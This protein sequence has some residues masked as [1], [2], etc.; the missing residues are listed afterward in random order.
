MHIDTS[1]LILRNFCQEDADD[2]FDYLSKPSTYDFEPGSPIT[3]EHVK[4]KG[5]VPRPAVR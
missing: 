5:I 2:L 1:R 3:R 4:G